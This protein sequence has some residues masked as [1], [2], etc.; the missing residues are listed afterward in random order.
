MP[1]KLNEKHRTPL[2]A[3]VGLIF[4][5]WCDV[6]KHR[7][8]MLRDHCCGLFYMAILRFDSSQLNDAYRRRLDGH[9]NLLHQIHE[10]LTDA[11]SLRILKK[12]IG[13]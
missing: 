11:C 1:C 4:Q 7:L 8:R 10:L 3:H 2:L 13:E 5:R 12:S 9:G 6:A